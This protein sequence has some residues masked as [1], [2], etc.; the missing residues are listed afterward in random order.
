[1]GTHFSGKPQE[2]RALD[3]YVKLSRC[4]SSLERRL[5]VTLRRTD[6][7]ENQ[8]GALEALLHLGPLAQCDLGQKLLTSRPNVTAVVDQLESEGLVRRER[9]TEDRRSV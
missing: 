3:A 5:T 4:T 7:S 8:F 2:M 6:L 1:M 9:S